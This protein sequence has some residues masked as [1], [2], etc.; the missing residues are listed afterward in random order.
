MGDLIPFLAGCVAVLI[1]EVVPAIGSPG[2]LTSYLDPFRFL[3]RGEELIQQGYNRFNGTVFRIPSVAGWKFV[4][5]GPTL[6]KDICYPPEDALS[7][8]EA[9][10]DQLQADLTLG[11]RDVPNHLVPTLTK[12]TR[13]CRPRFLDVR[14]ELVCAFDDTLELEGTDW[15]P[16]TVLPAVTDIVARISGRLFVGLPLWM[17]F[18]PHGRNPE[19]QKFSIKHTFDVALFG[20]LI[21]YLPKFLRPILGPLISSRKRNMRQ[22]MRLL[23]PLVAERIAL[24]ERHGGDWPDKPVS[25]WDLSVHSASL[26][27]AERL[28]SWLLDMAQPYQRTVPEVVQ[29]ILVVIMGAIHTLSFTFAEALLDLTTYTS[30]IEPLREEV[31]R[32]INKQGWTRAALVAVRNF[33]IARKV[34]HPDGFTFSDRTFL[35]TGSFLQVPVR[36]VHLDPDNFVNPHVFD[37]F[38]FYNMQSESAPEEGKARFKQYMVT[39]EPT[40]LAFGHGKH[41]CPGRWLK[42]MLAYIV[43]NYDIKL[44]TEGVRPPDKLFDTLRIPD[45]KAQVWFRK[46]EV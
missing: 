41:A 9:I 34:I 44:E 33:S 38:R 25:F 43:L 16:I 1:L 30:Y 35:P 10:R 28:I 42:T 19:Y 46:R 40:H 8:E 2:A 22:A 36:P 6:L 12:L 29:R 27:Q 31:E 23:G 20:R 4:A 17:H 39:T 11:P 45:P 3:L 21:G 18:P 32:I 24:F 15:K 14:D 7:F 5:S 13:N 26:M 37:G